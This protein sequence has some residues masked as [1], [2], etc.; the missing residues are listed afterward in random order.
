MRVTV[1]GYEPIWIPD[2][3]AAPENGTFNSKT[4]YSAKLVSRLG[5]TGYR[6]GKLPSKILCLEKLKLDAIDLGDYSSFCEPLAGVGLSVR[7][8]A[9]PKGKLY[10]NDLDEGCRKILELNFKCKVTGEDIYALDFP[11]ADMIFLDFNDFTY[12]RFLT[13]EYGSVLSRALSSAQKFVV[14]NDCSVFY[15]RYGESSFTAYSRLMGKKITSIEDYFRVAA[16]AFHRRYP[17]W[18]VSKVAY[19]RDTAFLLFTRKEVPLYIERVE[20]QADLVTVEK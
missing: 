4:P 20:A 8:F 13:S 7:I 5:S 19:F 11:K 10:L 14:L 1:R 2:S 3:L 9:R 18:W 16:E 15:F 12:K 6:E 17:A